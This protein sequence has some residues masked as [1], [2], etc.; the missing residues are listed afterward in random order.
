MDYKFIVQVARK[1]AQTAGVEQEV[2]EWTDVDEFSSYDEADG[3]AEESI[4]LGQNAKYIRVIE[5]KARYKSE[6]VVHK[7]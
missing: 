2:K 7:I 6:V 1:V 5:I 3:Y 4:K